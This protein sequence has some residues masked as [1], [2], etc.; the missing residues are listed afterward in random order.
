V[1]CEEL[2]LMRE[3]VVWLIQTCEVERKKEDWSWMG[4]F[5]KGEI[6]VRGR[7]CGDGILNGRVL[8]GNQLSSVGQMKWKSERG[9]LCEALGNG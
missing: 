9:K 1:G 7:F 6:C 5:L 4:R 8:V 2:L 3:I